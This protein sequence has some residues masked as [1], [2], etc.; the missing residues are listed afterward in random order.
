MDEPGSNTSK[1][2]VIIRLLQSSDSIEELTELLHRAYK[3]LV[4]MGINNMAATQSPDVTRRRVEVGEC[5]VAEMAGRLVGTITL[6]PQ[7][8]TKGCW[9]ENDRGPPIYRALTSWTGSIAA[10]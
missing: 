4:D 2:E 9:W 6:L 10:R 1:D 3:E 7:E 5:W 8:K